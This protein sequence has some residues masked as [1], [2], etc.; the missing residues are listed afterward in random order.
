MSTM[1]MNPAISGQYMLGTLPPAVSARA[2]AP[3]CSATCSLA[4]GKAQAT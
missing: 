2:Y 1:A 4:E 3:A